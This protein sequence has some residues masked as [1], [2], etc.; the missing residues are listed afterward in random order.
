MS[1]AQP[2]AQDPCNASPA[3]RAIA[4]GRP[5]AP[6]STPCTSP[7]EHSESPPARRS[8]T[9]PP[10]PQPNPLARVSITSLLLLPSVIVVRSQYQVSRPLV[11]SQTLRTSK[12][13]RPRPQPDLPSPLYPVPVQI[14]HRVNPKHRLA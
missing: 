3:L 5:I 6:D 1:R 8:I 14:P 9:S 13:V 11:L 2:L 4:S 7:S 10:I 12:Q